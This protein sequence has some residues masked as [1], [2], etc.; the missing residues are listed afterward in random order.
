M[1]TADD[2]FLQTGVLYLQA[3]GGG[4]RWW[5]PEPGAGIG[6]VSWGW[7]TSAPA[8]EGCI[9]DGG[10]HGGVGLR[11][12]HGGSGVSF[13]GAGMPWRVALG[14]VHRNQEGACSFKRGGNRA[15]STML[16]VSAGWSLAATHQQSSQ[17]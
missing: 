4:G 2:T 7:G 6:R 1:D 13:L 11:C 5:M 17:E 12:E 8:R 14:L 15:A 3:G 10:S 9:V 16:R